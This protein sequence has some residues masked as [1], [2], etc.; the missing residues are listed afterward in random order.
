[1]G[2]MSSWM[3]ALGKYVVHGWWPSARVMLHGMGY[4]GIR[5]DTIF[6]LKGILGVHAE[7]HSGMIH[8]SQAGGA[9]KCVWGGMAPLGIQQTFTRSRKEDL[10]HVAHQFVR[11]HD[12]A[13]CSG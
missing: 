7:E 4:L 8:C 5:G 11:S 2:V 1:M 3:S 6:L 13:T 12:I 10:T 9:V